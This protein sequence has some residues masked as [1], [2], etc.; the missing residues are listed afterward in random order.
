[1]KRTRVIWILA[2]VMVFL[3]SMSSAMAEGVKKPDNFPVKPIRMLIPYA[4]GG[5]SDMNARKLA[6]IIEVNKLMPQKLIVTNMQGSNTMECFNAL[7]GADP[8]GH[9]LVLQH[10]AI[11]TLP[12]YGIVNYTM[13][14]VDAVCEVLEQPLIIFARSEAPYNNT[15]ELLEYVKNNPDVKIPFGLPG[16]GSSGQTGAEIFL[17]ES[18]LRDHMLLVFYGGGGNT[19]SAQLGGEVVLSGGFATDGMRY[20]HSGEL[21]A[22]AVS[23]DRRLDIL[24]EVECFAELGFE[25]NYMTRQGIWATKGTPPEVL[26]YLADVFRQACDTDSYREYLKIQ[27]CEE[28]YRSPEDWKAIMQA[29]RV[30]IEALVEKLGLKVEQ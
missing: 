14:D 1:M 11:L 28:A 6:E 26:A 3:L 17:T 16:V 30:Q 2:I 13:E 21:K 15:A 29:D 5:N 18:G 24:P 25:N 23:G 19:L 10:T 20:V 4:A 7:F 9:T 27:G 8:D 22:I 12:A